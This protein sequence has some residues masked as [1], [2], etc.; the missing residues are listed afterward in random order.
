[1][2]ALPFC[3]FDERFEGIM[4]GEQMFRVFNKC[5]YDIGATLLSGQSV[6]IPAGK[7]IVMSVNDILHV[8]GICNKRKFFSAGM[9]VPTTDD[10]RELTLEELGGYTDNYT[11]ENQR[12]LSDEEI[13]QNLKKPFKAFE[14]WAKKIEDPSELDS[15]ITVAKKIDLNASKLR[16]LQALVPD[17]DLLEQDEDE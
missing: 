9:L 12:H 1:M 11:V 2:W 13:T 8:E 6:N 5:K 16:V 15:V 7:F 14:A 17:K 10:G 3:I 4:N